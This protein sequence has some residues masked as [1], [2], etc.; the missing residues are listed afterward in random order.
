MLQLFSNRCRIPPSK[1]CGPFKE[2]NS[3]VDIGFWTSADYNPVLFSAPFMALVVIILLYVPLSLIIRPLN[4]QNCTLPSVAIYYAR[5]YAEARKNTVQILRKRI[6]VRLNIL[7]L[8]ISSF[9][10]KMASTDGG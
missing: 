10:L 4:L 3:V 7:L 2:Y 1:S 9:A 5:A 8:G 6:E